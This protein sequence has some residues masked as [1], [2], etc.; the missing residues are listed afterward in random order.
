MLSILSFLRAGAVSDVEQTLACNVQMYMPPIHT[1]K[2]MNPTSHICVIHTGLER[3]LN[4][5]LQNTK[6]S[7]NTF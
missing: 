2:A 7:E 3:Q 1:E 6:I 5:N 4:L